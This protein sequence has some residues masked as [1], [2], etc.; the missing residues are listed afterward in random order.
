MWYA[1]PPRRVTKRWC[2]LTS[3]VC[4]SLCLSRTSGIT[5]EQRAPARPQL[6]QRWP[7]S[8]ATQTQLSRSRGQRST[9]RDVEILWLT[10]VHRLNSLT[11]Y[12]SWR[13]QLLEA[14]RSGRSRRDGWAAAG[15]QPPAY[16][17]RGHI[18][19]PRAQLLLFVCYARTGTKMA[20]KDRNVNC[21]K[22]SPQCT[23]QMKSYKK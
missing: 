1:P 14:R 21:K 22:N 3:D 18:V 16:S 15:P 6:A 12:Y 23:T 17:G 8:H 4:L 19:S 7:T 9:C 2:C 20:Y 13:R 5:R 11:R 10:R